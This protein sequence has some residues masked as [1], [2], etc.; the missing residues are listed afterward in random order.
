MTIERYLSVAIK[1][2]YPTRFNQKKAIILS[3]TIIS[4]ICLINFQLLIGNGYII[5][6]NGTASIVC[7][8]SKLYDLF[9]KSIPAKAIW[10]CPDTIILVYLYN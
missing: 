9:P 6:I 10:Q 1:N 8:D 4:A 7:Y 3:I 5:N 2:W